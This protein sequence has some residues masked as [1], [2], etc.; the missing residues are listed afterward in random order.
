MRITLCK[1]CGLHKNQW[2][3]ECKFQPKR[4]VNNKRENKR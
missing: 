3:N 1:H 4:Y 2:L